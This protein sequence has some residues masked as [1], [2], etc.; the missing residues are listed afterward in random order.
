[1][2]RYFRKKILLKHCRLLQNKQIHWLK[3]FIAIKQSPQ[4]IALGV[5]EDGHERF[6]TRQLFETEN[7]IQTLADKLQKRWHM[8]IPDQKK[9][10]IL[11]KYQEKISKFLTDEQKT[12]IDHLL[13]PRA[14]TCMVGR[15]GTG[16]SFC[17]GAAKSLWESQG[18]S[19]HGIAL[20]GIAADGLSKDVG[21]PSTTIASF[22][23]RVENQLLT[24]KQNDVVIMDEAGMTDSLSMFSV[25]KLIHKAKAKLVLVG[26]PAQLQPVGPGASFRALVERLGFVEIQHIYRQTIPWQREA[27]IAFSQ[28]A[29]AKGL[30]AYKTKNCIHIENTSEAAMQQLVQDWRKICADV[31]LRKNISRLHIAMMISNTQYLI[32]ILSYRR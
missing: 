28:G 1:M 19:V 26:D 8:R 16:K 4:I 21:L 10:T 24:L 29:I 12:A 25:L 30:A 6:T 23:F 2:N 3:L 7:H 31:H 18:L 32:K 9:E 17:L 13:K 14:I 22:C 15:A 27:T 5:G 20:S 11:T